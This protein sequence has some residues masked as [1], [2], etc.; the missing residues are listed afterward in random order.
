MF[1]Y[2]TFV[3]QWPYLRNNKMLATRVFLDVYRQKWTHDFDICYNCWWQLK[4]I[5][6]MFVGKL[7]LA[8]LLRWIHSFMFDFIMISQSIVDKHEETQRKPVSTIHIDRSFNTQFSE[9]PVKD[10]ALI[11][12]KHLVWTIFRYFPMCR[13][14]KINGKY[15]VLGYI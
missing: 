10:S 8:T 7:K 4:V 12:A 5:S 11:L 6:E 1:L 9:R 3:L 2:S 14:N 13:R 15:W